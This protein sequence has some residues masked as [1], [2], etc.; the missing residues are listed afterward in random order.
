VDD[1]RP[2]E[3]GEAGEGLLVEVRGIDQAVQAPSLTGRL[4][5]PSTG[6]SI[7]WVRGG[8]GSRG[9]VDRRGRAQPSAE[10]RIGPRNS[11]ASQSLGGEV[12]WPGMKPSDGYTGNRFGSATGGPGFFTYVPLRTTTMSSPGMT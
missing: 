3:G 11:L 4:L 12:P 9:C 6:G 10:A 5:G 1:G 8:E 7:P 2:V